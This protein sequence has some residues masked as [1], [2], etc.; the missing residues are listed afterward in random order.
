MKHTRADN[1]LTFGDIVSIDKADDDAQKKL[2]DVQD[3][4]AELQPYINKKL[5]ALSYQKKD[6]KED[7]SFDTS[8]RGGLREDG[9]FVDKNGQ[10]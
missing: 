2:K 4:I 10:E 6:K 5:N 8:R 3:R 9:V 7:E 1:T